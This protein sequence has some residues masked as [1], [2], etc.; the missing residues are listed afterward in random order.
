LGEQFF[1][2]ADLTPE[3]LILCHLLLDLLGDRLGLPDQSRK[4]RALFR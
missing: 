1:Q 2:A 3:G 4:S